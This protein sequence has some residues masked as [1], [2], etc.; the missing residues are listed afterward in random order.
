MIPYQVD[1]PMARLP[2][3]NW[4][5]IAANGLVFVFSA[6][7]PAESL[8][9]LLLDPR[10]FSAGQLL[11]SLFLHADIVHL[12]GNML[13]LFVFGNAVNAKLGHVG[14]LLSYFLIGV[15]EGLAWRWLGHGPALGASGAIMGI[16]GLFFVLFPRN[17]VEVFY[18]DLG[19][20]AFFTIPA[21]WLILLYIVWDLCGVVLWSQEGVA[22][23]CHL[24]GAVAGIAEG[25]L[26]TAGRWVKSTGYEENLWEMLQGRARGEKKIRTKK[27]RKSDVRD[28]AA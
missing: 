16:V 25:L 23:V 3:A 21:F 7:A 8:R 13:F 4:A 12:V 14:F 10:H 19:Y 20:G 17:D 1:V 28:T 9:P 27:R 26:L 2:W 5:L 24:A 22:Y 11:T 18:F 6:A 15:V